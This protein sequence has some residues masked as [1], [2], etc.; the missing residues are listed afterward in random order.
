MT[1]SYVN[2]KLHL[3]T[4]CTVYSVDRC[5]YSVVGVG[6][7]YSVVGVCTVYSVVGVGTV[8]SVQCR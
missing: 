3:G 5:R 7:V 6:T 2:A 8:Y 4:V 1:N